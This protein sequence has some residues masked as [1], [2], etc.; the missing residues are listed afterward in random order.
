M[1]LA[2]FEIRLDPVLA[3]EVATSGPEQGPKMAGSPLPVVIRAH[4]VA[5]VNDTPARVTMCG[6]S[7]AR[8]HLEAGDYF[9]RQGEGRCPQCDQAV[10][11]RGV[12]IIRTE[13]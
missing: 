13:A 4:A 9:E 10:F 12:N 1:H 6:R 11:E 5:L 3:E 8:L 2:A 7:T